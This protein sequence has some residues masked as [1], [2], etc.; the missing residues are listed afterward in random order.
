MG[1]LALHG[2]ARLDIAKEL[3]TSVLYFFHL[4]K[5]FSSLKT[6]GSVAA[7]I[8]P[9]TTNCTKL[10]SQALYFRLPWKAPLE[11]SA[12]RLPWKAPLEGSPG[13]PLWE[14]HPGRFPWKALWQRAFQRNLP[15]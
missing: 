9:T 5:R 12:G 1:L 8:V 7:K 13:R 3:R 2:L 11:G 10:E 6:S 4:G 14:A 15:G